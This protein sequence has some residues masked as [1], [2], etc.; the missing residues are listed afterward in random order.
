MRTGVEAL[1]ATYGTVYDYGSSATTICIN[2]ILSKTY[3]NI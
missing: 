1:T 3:T 2:Y